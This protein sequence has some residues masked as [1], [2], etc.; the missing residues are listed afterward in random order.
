MSK[1]LSPRDLLIHELKDL[2]SAENQ[3][4]KALPKMA[5]AAASEEL[6]QAFQTHL[7]QTEEHIRRLE[8]IG[9]QL[10]ETLKGKKCKAM[11]G[12]VEEGKEIIEEEGD[13]TVLDLALIGAAQKVEHYEIASYGTARTLAELLGEDQIATILQETLDEEGETDKLLTEIAMELNLEAGVAAGV[14]DED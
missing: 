9:K 4:T 5:K 10:D 12:L 8:K 3:L 1:L 14:D 13:E 7:Q 11:E 2:Y 6:K